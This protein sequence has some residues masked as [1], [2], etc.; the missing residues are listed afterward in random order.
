MQEKQIK[1]IQTGSE[2]LKLSLFAD[3][4]G[5][6]KDSST[7]LLE[8]RREFG[9]VVGCKI[10]AALVYT[11]NSVVGEEIVTTIPKYFVLSLTKDVED[12]T[13]L[14]LEESHF[15]TSSRSILNF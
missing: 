12:Q 11:N 15:L 5:E 10:K 4:M 3:D 9:R 7:R 14:K 8:H 6:P 2:E 13:K 1:G